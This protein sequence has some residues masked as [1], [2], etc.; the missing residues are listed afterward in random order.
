M[1]AEVS[2]D[3]SAATT[4]EREKEDPSRKRGAELS[5]GSSDINFRSAAT[6]HVGSSVAA[7]MI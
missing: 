3:L 2:L 6:G 5:R 1:S 7:S 4:A